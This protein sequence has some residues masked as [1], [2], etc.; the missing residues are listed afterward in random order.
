[1]NDLLPDHYAG[2]AVLVYE[3]GFHG[4][5]VDLR[6]DHDGALFEWSADCAV[7]EPLVSRWS[8]LVGTGVT[9]ILPSLV[10]ADAL[11]SDLVYDGAGQGRAHLVANGA[12][13][14]LS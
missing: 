1:M 13:R 3:G 4:V 8:A 2:P 14:R 5:E 7:T 9:I 12:P 10:V 11:V 6:V